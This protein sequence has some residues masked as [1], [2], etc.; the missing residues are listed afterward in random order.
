VDDDEYKIISKTPI[1]TKIISKLVLKSDL[2]MNL[3]DT[4]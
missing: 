2:K 4:E 1:K 3:D